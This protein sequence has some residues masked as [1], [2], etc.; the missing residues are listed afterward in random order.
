MTQAIQ[1][2]VCDKIQI[3]SILPADAMLCILFTLH[4]YMAIISWNLNDKLQLYAYIL[5]YET[6]TKTYISFRFFL[7]QFSLE[8]F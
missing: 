5:K 7:K 4:M 6:S 3:M 2:Y 8:D 1:I